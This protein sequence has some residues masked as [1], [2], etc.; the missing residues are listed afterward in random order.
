VRAL[1]AVVFDFFGTL[2][3]AV[4]RGRYHAGIARSLG[5]DPTEFISLLDRT[6]YL[7]ALGTFGTPEE[8]LRWMCRQLGTD[9]SPAQLRRAA[10]ARVHALRAD[11]RLRPEAVPVLRA[12]RRRGLYTAVVSDCGYELAGFLPVLPIAPLI[13]A[14]VYSVQVGHCKPHPEIFLA[15]CRRL[16]VGPEECLYVGDGGSRELTGASAVGMTAVRL[17]APDLDRHLTFQ[18]DLDWRGPAVASLGDVPALSRVIVPWRH[19]AAV[20]V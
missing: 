1:R 8:T 13:D 9:P 17:A 7:R 11:T 10:R 6:F 5:C 18:P 16:G 14:T 4:Q 19:R 3:E 2:T 20:P 12:L 15:A